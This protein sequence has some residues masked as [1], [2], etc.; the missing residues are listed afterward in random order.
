MSHT[1]FFQFQFEITSTWGQA[2]I[3]LVQ[4]IGKRI[5]AVTDDTRETFLF[6]RLPIGL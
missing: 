5:A 1:S 2:S 6:Q 4:E 3:E